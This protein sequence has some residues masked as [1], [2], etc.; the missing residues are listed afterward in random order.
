MFQ[1]PTS[2]V[3]ID[4]QFFHLCGHSVFLSYLLHTVSGNYL[5]IQIV[6]P[7]GYGTGLGRLETEGRDGES[8]YKVVCLL[9]TSDI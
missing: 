8:C 4:V 7:A 5:A 6:L 3:I 9:S 1:T 2:H